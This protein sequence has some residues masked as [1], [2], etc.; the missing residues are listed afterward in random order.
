MQVSG[1]FA[2]SARAP[3]VSF[4]RCVCVAPLPVDL[5]GVVQGTG[6]PTPLSWSHLFSTSSIVHVGYGVEGLGWRARW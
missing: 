3:C 5:S 4:I 2:W 1:S 6:A